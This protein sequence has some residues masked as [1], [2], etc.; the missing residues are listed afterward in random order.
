MSTTKSW[1]S[2]GVVNVTPT[3]YSIPQA[4]DLNWASLTDFLVA[5]AQGAQSTTFQR[6]ANR[7]AT[8]SP[9]NVTQLN[10]CIVCTDL[11]VP[12][13]V[14][15]ILPSGVDKQVFIISDNKGDAV[16]NNITITPDGIETIGGAATYVMATNFEAVMLVFQASTGNWNIA[17]KFVPNPS[18]SSVGGFTPNISIISNGAGNLTSSSTTATEIGYVSGVTSSIQTQL[19]NKQPLD[20]DLTALAALTTTGFSTRTGAA[21]WDTRTFTTGSSK[22]SLTNGDGI[23]GNPVIDAVEANFTLNNIGGTLSV[24]K[25]GTG[26]T[27]VTTAPTPTAFAGWDANSNFSANSFIPGYATTAT[28]GG[29]LTLTVASQQ[30]Q[31]L[32]GTLT[33]TVTLPVTSTLVLGQSFH[34]VNNSTQNV[35][36]NS[37]G[38]NLIQTMGTGSSATYTVIL[39]SGTTA[40]SWSKEYATSAAGTVTSVDVSGGTTGLTTSGGPVTTSGT[41]TLAGTLIVANGGTG[42]TSGTSGG[43]PTYTASGTLTS[44]DALTN[45]QLIVGGGAGAVIKTLAAGSANQY[46]KISSGIPTWITVSTPTMQ[47]FTNPIY[48]FTIT[49]AT[50]TAGSTYTNNGHTFQLTRSIS[51][52]T[53]ALL[54][55]VTGGAPAASG[56]LT[57]AETGVANLTF[58]AQTLSSGATSGT[59]TPTA[60]TV[61]FRARLVGGG[62]GGAGGG[63]AGSAGSGG[64]GGITSLT[65]NTGTTVLTAG[66]ASGGLTNNGN[67]Q[68][69]GNATIVSASGTALSGGSASPNIAGF[70]AATGGGGNGASSPFGG[71]GGGAFA[72]SL[73]TA[74]IASTG[75]GGGGGGASNSS[76]Q[77]GAGGAAGG[78]IDAIVS[79]VVASYAYVIAAGGTAGAAGTNGAAGGAGGSGYIEITEYYI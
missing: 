30:L 72:S 13:P 9:V 60:G 19:D 20:A 71:R 11:A 68:F 33:H 10:D 47:I 42:L 45:N 64:T 1:P 17:G 54:I 23:A 3:P 4:G 12:G 75:S 62:G 76:A 58:S 66:G 34:I 25:G 35:T 57:S 53:T 27:S 18:G 28:S 15:V 39:T 6:F 79:T 36:V 70:S 7:T 59:Y 65:G 61:W 14:S 26:V 43:V 67:S 69:G 73:G 77:W 48:S 5:L 16:T 41:I 44:S 63:T 2:Q 8:S 29:N 49:S 22:I 52:A 24:A 21:T 74:A 40:A 51:S 31:Y 78:Y 38:G 46:L 32:T 37:S 55:S 56:T 50:A